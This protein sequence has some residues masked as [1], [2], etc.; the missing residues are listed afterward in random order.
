[1]SAET[2]EKPKKIGVSAAR[3]PSTIKNFGELFQALWD[4]FHLT[5]TEALKELNASSQEEIT[6]LPSEC[7]Q[8]IATV[9]SG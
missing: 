9:R 8:R 3:D 1:M 2:V 4:D 5:K 7:Y 6:E